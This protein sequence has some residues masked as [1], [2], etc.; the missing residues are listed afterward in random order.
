MTREEA[1]TVAGALPDDWEFIPVR[2]VGFFVVKEN[3]IHCW[4]KS[5]AEGR[6]ITRSDI[7]QVTAPL[8]A[9]YGHVV[10]S[11]R[12]QNIYGHRFVQRLG[13]RPDGESSGCV[14]YRAERMKHARL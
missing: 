7:E 9:K 2:D 12:K 13:F 4:R 5:E 14:R 8:L 6:W 3:E 10:T 11:V 1:I